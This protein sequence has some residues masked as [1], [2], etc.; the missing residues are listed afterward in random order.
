MDE[1]SRPLEGTDQPVA[2]AG[3][4]VPGGRISGWD[5]LPLRWP[6]G[7]EGGYARC[8]CVEFMDS[9]EQRVE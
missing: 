1:S 7:R 5:V 6:G 8:S 4:R 9:S 2:R 3:G